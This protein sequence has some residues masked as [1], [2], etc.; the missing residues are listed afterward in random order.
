M[1]GRDQGGGSMGGRD[2]R[3]AER[4]EARLVAS[5]LPAE[6]QALRAQVAALELAS[7]RGTKSTAI[8]HSLQHAPPLVNGRVD[9]RQY[10]EAALTKVHT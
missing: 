5:R 3:A 9:W 7:G 10:E 8:T 6:L 1:G 4:E 2:P